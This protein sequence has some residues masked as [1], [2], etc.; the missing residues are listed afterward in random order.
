MLKART[1]P[2]PPSSPRQALSE[3]EGI[4]IKPAAFVVEGCHPEYSRV[5][6]PAEIFNDPV[7]YELGAVAVCVPAPAGQFP[8]D[9]N[10]GLV[11]V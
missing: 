8:F 9:G 7:R 5:G 3:P 6:I 11:L 4:I 2:W 1:L 10:V